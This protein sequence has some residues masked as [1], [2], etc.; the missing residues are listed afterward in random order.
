MAAAE[1]T[2]RTIVP[3]FNRIAVIESIVDDAERRSGLIVPL[4]FDGSSGIKRGVVVSHDPIALAND[5]G[6]WVKALVPGR[7]VY[8]RETSGV[9]IGDVRVLE[10]VDVIAVEP[11]DDDVDGVP[12]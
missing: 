4:A 6:D 2:M 8:Y 10:V 1:L 7:V 9:Q 5:P 3:F 11:L 12:S